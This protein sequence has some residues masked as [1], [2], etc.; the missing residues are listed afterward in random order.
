MIGRV[1]SEPLQMHI[2]HEVSGHWPRVASDFPWVVEDEHEMH[3][4]SKI[5]GLLAA[6]EVDSIGGPNCVCLFKMPAFG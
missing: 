2:M 4:E 6:L 5:F 3:F 1:R